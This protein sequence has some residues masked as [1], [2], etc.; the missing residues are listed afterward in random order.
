VWRNLPAAL[1]ACLALAPVARTQEEAP[2]TAT[3]RSEERDAALVK[4]VRYLDEHLWKLREGGSPRRQYTMAVAGWAYLLASDKEG[5][6]LPARKRQLQR[7]HKELV[8]YAERVAKLY[9]RD[10]KRTKKKRK[11]DADPRGALGFEAL[12]TAQYTWTLSIAA[13]F[14]AES[15]ARGQRKGES[16]KALKA[17]VRVL[18]ASQQ[19]SGGWGHDDASRPGMGLPPIRIPKPGGGQLH[20]PGTLLAASHCAL[21]GLGVA[22]RSLKTRRAPSLQ[23]GRAY[24]ENSQNGDGTFPYDPAQ[25]HGMELPTEMAGGI[26]IAR[27]SGAVFALLCAGAPTDDPVVRRALKSI[28]KKPE[29]MSE[30]HGSATMALQFGALLS[31]GREEPSWETFRE[32]FVPRILSHQ[33]KNGAFAC[34]CQHKS[35]AV[36][37][38]TRPIPGVP[39][40]EMYVREQRVY[41][42]AIHALILAL[43]R[44]RPRALPRVTGAVTPR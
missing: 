39:G 40:M 24:F 6:R 44:S 41:V 33:E 17:I 23:K 11:A 34:V 36:T 26:E 2:A 9:D 7:I 21:S 28:D 30:G 38:D 42:T 19:E 12:R 43:D 22:H 25:K 8:R 14:F 5:S 3:V 18:E 31:R 16:R 10:D 35:G 15:H 1:L 4:A 27:T 20:Y 32:I 29:L 13:H 37:C